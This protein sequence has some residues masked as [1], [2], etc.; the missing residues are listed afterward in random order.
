MKQCWWVEL[1]NKALLVNSLAVQWLGLVAF[2]SGA[3]GS[4]P[5]PLVGGLAM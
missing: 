1:L 4:I 5:G 3:W 2:T